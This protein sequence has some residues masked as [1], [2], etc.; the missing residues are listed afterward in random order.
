[1][2]MQMECD[3][4][5]ERKKKKNQV[6]NLLSTFISVVKYIIKNML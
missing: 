3:R 5:Q 6:L 1:M 2:T 4:E